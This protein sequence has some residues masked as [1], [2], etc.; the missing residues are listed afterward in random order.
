M[1]E[2]LAMKQLLIEFASS[3][4]VIFACC[5]GIRSLNWDGRAVVVGFAGGDIP[6]IPANILLVKNVEVSGLYWGAAAVHN[7]E[8]FKQ[9]S[10][11]VISMWLQG[12]IKPHVSHRIPLA[13]ANTALGIIKSRKSTGKVLLVDE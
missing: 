3:N 6:T 2:D 1:R 5:T 10:H 9:S 13:E 7:P 4:T 11:E 12:S 8:L